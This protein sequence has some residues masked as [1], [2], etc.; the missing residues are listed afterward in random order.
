MHHL[1]GY[2]AL[3][4]A[5]NYIRSNVSVISLC[6]DAPLTLAQ[7]I[8]EYMLAKRGL[9]S[10][11]FEGPI[12]FYGAGEQTDEGPDAL[13]HVLPREVQVSTAGVVHYV[14]LTGGSELLVVAPC[15]ELEVQYGEKIEIQQWCIR[16]RQPI[17]D[18]F[19]NGGEQS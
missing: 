6:T 2:D 11:Y 1:I 7:A 8:S 13:M 10:S 9:S 12:E 4:A 5:L 16:V 15:S 14:A 19:E 3:A 17:Q 18:C